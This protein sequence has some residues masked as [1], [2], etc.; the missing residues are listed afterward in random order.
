[1]GMRSCCTGDTLQQIAA[2]LQDTRNILMQIPC[3]L[4]IGLLA[5][6]CAYLLTRTMAQLA[7]FGQNSSL[8]APRLQLKAVLLP[9][10]LPHLRLQPSPRLPQH[11]KCQPYPAL[12]SLPPWRQL[13]HHPLPLPTPLAAPGISKIVMSNSWAFVHKVKRTAQGSATNFGCQQGQFL[14]ARPVMIHVRGTRSVA[15]RQFARMYK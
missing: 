6:V 3:P 1:M 2:A 11:R 9:E 8:T 4:V 15:R 5:L 14:V 12:Q 7:L 13:H 10:V